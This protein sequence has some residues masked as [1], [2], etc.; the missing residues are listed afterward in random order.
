MDFPNPDKNIEIYLALV[1]FGLY[2]PVSKR[3][4]AMSQLYCNLVG[5]NFVGEMFKE[6][7]FEGH[8]FLYI[9]YMIC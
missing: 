2:E 1:S 5:S 8:S 3:T 4:A 6:N 9:S 7:I